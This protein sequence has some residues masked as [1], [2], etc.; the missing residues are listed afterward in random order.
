MKLV[1][2]ALF[3]VLALATAIAS[4]ASISSFS[5][6]PDTVV[7][8]IPS[9][10][11]ISLDAPAA[12]SGQVV[13]LSSSSASAIVPSSVLIP[14]GQTTV[15]FPISTK[16]VGA[17]V[18]ATI[19]ASLTGASKNAVLTLN[20]AFITGVTFPVPSIL[21]GKKI[22]GT[23]TLNGPAPAGGAKV[24]L[25][26]NVKEVGCPS[27]V[28]VPEG[29]MMATFTASSS[30]V[31][32]P[33]IA[34]ITATLGYIETSASFTVNPVGPSALTLN[35]ASMNGKGTTTATVTLFGP[36]DKDGLM[37]YIQSSNG[38]ASVPSSVKVPEGQSS[39]TFPISTQWVRALTPVTILVK[40]GAITK[41][42]VLNIQAPAVSA[43]T[44]LPGNL[45]GGTP[46]V[47][48]VTLSFESPPFGTV[49]QLVGD[50]PNV[51]F[52]GSLSIPAGKTSGT[53]N[54]RT[55]EIGLTKTANL[56]A[57]VN[58]AGPTAT[59]V[60]TAPTLATFTASLPV[61][62]STK[63]AP[64]TAPAT[65]PLA[66][67]TPGQ[68]VLTFALNAPAPNGGTLATIVTN[69]KNFNC[70]SR[71]VI[72]TGKTSTTVTFKVDKVKANTPVTITATS[73]GTTL[74]A[75]IVLN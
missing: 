25:V 24:T 70:P 75:P 3:F 35:P 67:K 74:T 53:F 63:D 7:G 62:S 26:S 59:L 60:V 71:V 41:T 66:V 27:Q 4:A 39:V 36:A 1:K 5:V 43:F 16:N 8:G 42:A 6:V 69:L 68:I 12:A 28:N 47:G 52:Q 21:A 45:I 57:L 72:P 73:N 37:V 30:F 49:V 31:P 64:P 23:V 17:Q 54:I 50:A 61:P 44:V 13:N 15:T 32:I 11:T 40:S 48:T 22:T 18:L 10:G 46:A 33:T 55:M 58:G 2:S 9:V 20:P 14:S 56:K 19:T 34:T 29:Q 65:T 51:S 38:N